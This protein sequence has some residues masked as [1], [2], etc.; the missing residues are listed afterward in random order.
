MAAAQPNEPSRIRPLWPN[1]KSIFSGLV[2]IG[3][4]GRDLF[5]FD[6]SQFE[7][8]KDEN[9]QMHAEL[10]LAGVFYPRQPVVVRSPAR[11]W[12]IVY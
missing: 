10:I 8:T 4:K 1:S 6:Q 11:G 12:E 5:A 7:R 2:G 9:Q 3:R